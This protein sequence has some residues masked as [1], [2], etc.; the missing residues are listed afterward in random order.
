MANE[1]GA[2]PVTIVALVPVVLGLI[3]QGT[4][5]PS[6]AGAQPPDFS[7]AEHALVDEHVFGGLPSND[8][9]HVRRGYVLGYLPE[10]RIPRWVA[11]HVTPDYRRVPPRNGRY[12]TFRVDPDIPSAARD[13]DYVGLEGSR[14][15]V[16]GHLAPYAVM[17]GDRDH[18]GGVSPQDADEDSTIFQANYMSNIAPQHQTGFNGS[19]GLWNELERKVQDEWVEGDAQNLWVFAGSVV[20]PG[21]HELVG[22][23]NDIVVPPMFWKIVIRAPETEGELPTVLA[24]LFP[25]QRVAH[26]DIED[27]LVSVDI[28]EALTGLDFFTDL[29]PAEQH[30]LEDLDTSQNWAAFEG[31]H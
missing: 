13:A 16:R 4:N 27:F 12:R 23:A 9:V 30:T 5:P 24:F 14:G 17:G 25:H 10:A 20:G 28:V 6:G 1:N 22:P 8:N 15:L 11:Y 7:P 21:Q 18:D 29:D 2:R 26:G 3:A 19:G 31:G